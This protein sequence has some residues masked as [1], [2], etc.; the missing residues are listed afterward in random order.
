MSPF[1][2]IFR[3]AC[4]LP[5]ELDHRAYWAIKNLNLSLDEVGKHRL[6]QLWELQELRHNAYENAMI[7]KEKTKAFHDRHIQ[8]RSF[9]VNN[10]VSLYNSRLKLFP[11]KLRSI[12]D[13]LYVILQLFD[14]GSVLISDIKLGRQFNVNGHHFKP[15]L[16]SE[17][18]AHA[19]KVDPHLPKHSR[20]WWYLP[21]PISSHRFY[22]SF[23][24]LKTLNLA[25]LGGTPRL[26]YLLV[27]FVFQFFRYLRWTTL[28]KG[29]HARNPANKH[30]NLMCF[31]NPYFPHHIFVSFFMPWSTFFAIFLLEHVVFV[32]GN[33]RF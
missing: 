4:H 33:K 15:Y 14:G 28:G 12:W 30:H 11:G 19:D 2:L 16:T 21:R 17:P 18:P 24:W 26:A 10:K 7:Y 27:F 9:Q 13:G 20:T 3:K 32:D 23:V 25:L 6:L 1:R 31:S 5:V 8:R 29:A 22:F